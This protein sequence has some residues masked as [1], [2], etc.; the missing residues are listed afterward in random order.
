[1]AAKVLV[2][3]SMQRTALHA[4]ADTE[5]SISFRMYA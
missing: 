3:K 2:N 1:M 4:A 5:R